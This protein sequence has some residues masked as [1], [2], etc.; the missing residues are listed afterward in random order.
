MNTKEVI[1]FRIAAT[2]VPKLKIPD[3]RFAFK[4]ESNRFLSTIPCKQGNLVQNCNLLVEGDAPNPPDHR[5]EL[6]G[7]YTL[8]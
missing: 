8:S 1:T 6:C 3:M 2:G 7:L 4:S 5:A